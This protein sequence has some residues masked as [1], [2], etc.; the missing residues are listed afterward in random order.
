M[1]YE[2]VNE[3]ILLARIIATPFQGVNHHIVIRLCEKAGNS[4]FKT[5][6]P[7][8]CSFYEDDALRARETRNLDSLMRR[9]IC[10]GEQGPLIYQYQSGPI[11][12]GSLYLTPGFGIKIGGD[13]GIFSIV[14]D[15]HFPERISS[16]TSLV[17][18]AEVIL[19]PGD[20]Q[21]KSVVPLLIAAR[22][23][24]GPRSISKVVGSGTVIHR[25]KLQLLN[26]FT[27]WHEKAT[28][29]RVYITKPNGLQLDI[30]EQDPLHFSGTTNITSTVFALEYDKLNI[31]CTFYNPEFKAVVVDAGS[32]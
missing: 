8:D 9:P 4:G 24:I 19:E 28:A 10:L 26:V 5:G 3:F 12:E 23:V 21:M 27:H 20:S 29:V 2:L 16:N 22:G 17:S 25:N 18:S 14:A 11:N 15:F 6:L 13:S 31:E 1:Q 7:W 30:L 32:E